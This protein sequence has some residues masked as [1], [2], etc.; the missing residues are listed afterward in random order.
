MKEKYKKFM[1]DKYGVD[2]YSH[3]IAYISLIITFLLVVFKLNNYLVVPFIFIS[4]S[5]Y[6]VFS[7]NIEV[8]NK[9]N[10]KYLEM[11]NKFVNSL[12]RIKKFTIGSKTHRYFTCKSCKTELRIPKGKGKIKVKCPKCGTEYIKRT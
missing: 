3:F 5:L 8:R 10:I 1:H 7:K 2:D 4:Y 9:E 12:A 6:R 11:K